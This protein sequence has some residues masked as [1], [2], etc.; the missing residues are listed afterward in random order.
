LAASWKVR[1]EFDGL[2]H[3]VGFGFPR[4][5]RAPSSARSIDHGAF[6]VCDGAWHTLMRRLTDEV[7]PHFHNK[8]LPE[9]DGELQY[10]VKNK[11]E[12]RVA[13][14][15]LLAFTYMDKASY[16]SST[17]YAVSLMIFQRSWLHIFRRAHGSGFR[18]TM[19]SSG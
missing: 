10:R 3:V 2:G 9:R 4:A 11:A 15:S 7:V 6:P 14:E 19:T 17:V 13:L 5:G 8:P 1:G 12:Q 18:K 16:R